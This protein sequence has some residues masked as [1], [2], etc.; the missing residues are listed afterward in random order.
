[1]PEE[2]V[3]AMVEFVRRGIIFGLISD[4]CYDEI[5]FEAE[6]VSAAKFD[7]DDRVISVFSCSKTYSMT[8][9]RL[10]YTSAQTAGP[11]N[12]KASDR[13]N[14]LDQLTNESC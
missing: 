1:M 9:W 14:K 2:T 11:F 3:K 13:D 12:G 7:E 4:E 6:H 8:G 10:G 5:V